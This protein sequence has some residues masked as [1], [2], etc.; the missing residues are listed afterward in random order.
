M[1]LTIKKIHTYPGND[2]IDFTT[3]FLEIGSVYALLHTT[4]N[5]QLGCI[6]NFQQIISYCN[7]DIATIKK[8][9]PSLREGFPGKN[10]CL[11]DVRKQYET[12]MDAVFD[13]INIV[14][15]SEY[16]STNGSDMIIY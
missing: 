6:S 4:G 16:K 12:K 15:K 8:V 10:L 7:G 13:K 1:K 3:G 2:T 14:M 9:L 11:F 5:C